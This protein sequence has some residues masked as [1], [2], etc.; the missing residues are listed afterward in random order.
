MVLP[1][2]IESAFK[3]AEA[4]FL[5]RS[6]VVGIAI[7]HSEAQALVFF[8]DRN[9]T[10]ARTRIANWAQAIGVL[11]EIRISGKL[12]PARSEAR[13]N[14]NADTRSRQFRRAAKTPPG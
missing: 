2:P 12:T 4:R 1:K 11:A 10:E 7:D 5:G 14:Q 6:H 8:L 13:E 3:E 9:A